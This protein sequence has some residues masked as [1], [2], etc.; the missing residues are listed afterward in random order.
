MVRARSMEMYVRRGQY[1]GPGME[2]ESETLAWSGGVLE[3]VSPVLHSLLC[4]T[5]TKI[6][7]LRE[8]VDLGA[9]CR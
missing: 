9:R 6:E 3:G 2:V 7:D 4:L 8:I 1:L 5:A